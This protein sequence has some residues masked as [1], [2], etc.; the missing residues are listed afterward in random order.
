MNIGIFGGTFN[1]PHTGHMIVAEH[2][3]QE[4]GMERILFVPTAVPPHKQE[5]DIAEAQHRLAMVRCAI[6]GNSNFEVSET[7]I[8]R[9][10]VS[11][12]VDTLMEF[13]RRSPHDAF[14]LLLGTDNVLEFHTWKDPEK[15][16]ELA[17]IVALTRPGFDIERESVT[18]KKMIVC[19]VPE[20][21]IA[22]S[23]IRNRIKEGRSV[24]Y[25]VPSAVETY[26]KEHQLYR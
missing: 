1:P 22:S 2:V 24:R 12:T 26:I 20:I 25:L 5:L 16:I 14:F 17:T 7:E 8:E 11:F 3:R 15:I 4:L 18:K 9:G 10:G 13:K 23:T 19:E 21:E 6:Q